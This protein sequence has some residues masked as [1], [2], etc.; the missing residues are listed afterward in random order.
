MPSESDSASKPPYIHTLLAVITL[1][2]EE[3]ENA[4]LSQVRFPSQSPRRTMGAAVLSHAESAGRRRADLSI[5]ALVV[6]IG[7]HDHVADEDAEDDD[8]GLHEFVEHGCC[9]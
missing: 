7:C 5:G 1:F 9:G 2:G 8:C 4:T 6:D 3:P